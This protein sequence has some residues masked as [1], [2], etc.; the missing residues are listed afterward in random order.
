MRKIALIVVLILLTGGGCG[1]SQKT[2]HPLA[3][4]PG[5]LPAG[6]KLP[7][8]IKEAKILREK[9]RGGKITLQDID[10]MLEIVAAGRDF[11]ACIDRTR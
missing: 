1:F 4:L 6:E 8:A 10:A 7:E 2:L 3:C 11:A 9:I 5:L